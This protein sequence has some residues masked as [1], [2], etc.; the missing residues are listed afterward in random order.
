MLK[1]SQEPTARLMLALALA[2]QL[3]GTAHAQEEASP[4]EGAGDLI[5]DTTP[6][7]APVTDKLPAPEPV[8]QGAQGP[9]I[10]QNVTVNL[11][12][13][14][15]KRGVLS[16]EDAKDLMAQAEADAQAAQAK[17]QAVHQA[18]Q[19]ATAPP[20]EDGD[21]GVAY[22]PE[23]VK[24]QMRTQ[25]K[26]EL[27]D[28][29]KKDQI[30]GGDKP[31]WAQKFNL[32]GDFRMRYDNTFFPLGNQTKSVSDGNGGVVEVPKGNAFG[33]FPDFN[34]INNGSPFDLAG[35][36]YSP[37]LNVSDNRQRL[38]LRAR[39]GSEID[40]GDDFDLGFRVATG[41]NSSPVS[42]NQSL[43]SSGGE[44]SKYAVWLDRAFLSYNFG[45]KPYSDITLYLGRFENP[46]FSSEVM[47]DDDIGFDGLAMK[48]KFETGDSAHVFA[49]AG[50]FP[51]FNS[52][53]NLSSSQTGN[54]LATSN[55]WLTGVQ[56]GIDWKITDKLSTKFGVAY[57]DFQNI[58]GKLSSPYIPLTANDGSDTDWS[59]PSFAQK[60]N[61]YMQIRNIAPDSSNGEGTQYQYQYFGLATP[62]R[63]VAV[64]HRID[65]DGYEPVRLSLVNEVIVNTAWNRSDVAA[66]AVNNL[67]DYKYDSNGDPIE[68]SNKYE[69]G[70]VAWYSNFIFG[71]PDLSV[72]GNWQAALGYRYVES[73]SV[74]DGFTE[75]DFGG[76]GTN[77]KGFSLGVNYALT[78]Y[79]RL[80][81][82]W[83]SADQIAGP[84]LKQDILQF[85]IN[86][87]F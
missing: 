83:M 37:Q 10:S 77:L 85:D 44:F 84:T 80:G 47:W 70:N 73:D 82:R 52:A 30:A 17:D 20:M 81:T 19:E 29:F 56:T 34:K 21:M 8:A 36:A 18:I 59:R 50:L 16:P 75:S 87:K 86:A 58:E 48:G 32:F 27:L 4:A 55:K 79:V 72:A 2:T 15:V 43:G 74:V 76:G 5:G 61:T 65:Y 45:D 25:I 31:Q 28:E 12:N 46:F 49:A 53:F 69:G 42:T 78:P 11:I 51:V 3:A 13:R 64:T 33:S 6:L 41:E 54:Q 40:L 26:A 38:R 66:N 60:G 62:F 63:D 7:E 9:S 71:S 57:Y 67:G 23:P 1:T 22:V 14:L 68:D 39:L 35:T 24:E